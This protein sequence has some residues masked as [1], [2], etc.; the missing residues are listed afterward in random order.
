MDMKP[1]ELKKARSELIAYGGIYGVRWEMTPSGSADGSLRAS[2][3]GGII[4]V[5]DMNRPSVGF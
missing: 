3:C 2:V 4:G 1:D 5:A